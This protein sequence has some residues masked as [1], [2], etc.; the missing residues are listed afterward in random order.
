MNIYN[1]TQVWPY[2]YICT[3]KETGHFYIGY[4]ERNRQPPEIDLPKYKTSSKIV[5]P[6]FLDYNWCIIA[7]FFNG[8]DAYDFEQQLIS[9]HW[10]D[11][12]LINK[13]C[14]FRNKKR[15]KNNTSLRGELN[16][17]FGKKLPAEHCQNMSLAK[18]GKMPANLELWKKSASN[19]SWVYN[20]TTLH[21]IRLKKGEKIPDGY[22]AGN[23]TSAISNSQHPRNPTPVRCIELNMDFPTVKQA[24]EFVGLKCPR[25]IVDSI[26]GKNQRKSAGG[27]HWEFVNAPRNSPMG[28]RT[29]L[30]LP[31]Y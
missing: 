20:P 17:R 29:K 10:G 31:V 15:F 13:N 3:H 23:I 25:D 19:T 24:A 21:Q 2:V 26:I 27:Y 16:P 30:D 4:R 14:Q 9:E 12:L 6:N 1:S 18:K 22:V 28:R 5:K 8:N 11:P 7:T